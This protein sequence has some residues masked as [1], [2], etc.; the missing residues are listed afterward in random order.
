MELVAMHSSWLVID[1]IKGCTNNCKYCL[2]QSNG[3]NN[4]K[5]KIIG[6][7]KE[8]VDQLLNFKYYDEKIPL[9]LLPSTDAFLNQDNINYL[10]Q[11]LTEINNRN[12]C[13]DLILIT[14]CF[15]PDETIKLLKELKNNNRNVIVY[16]SYSGLDKDIEPNIKK[17]DI[18]SNF[19]RL[20][21]AGI[22]II[23]YFRPFIPQNS[24]PEKIEEVLNFVNNYTNTSTIMG[25]KLIKNFIDKLE[26]WD[27]V[28][29]QKEEC[30]NAESVWTEDAW[31]YFY[32]NYSHPQ[33][34]F[35]TNTCA[36]NYK[37]NKPSTQYYNCDEC[38][39]YNYCDE[40]QRK[41]CESS[42]KSINKANVINELYSHL[43]KLNIDTNN[44]DYSFDSN[45]GLILKN[46]RLTISDLSYLS[47]MLNVKVYQKDNKPF[48]E[49]Y[50][51]ALNGAK[52]KVMKKVKQ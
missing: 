17:E 50:N 1:S 51:S 14:K 4:H 27:E 40:K 48:E 37:L 7:P 36:L 5:P 42:S 46:V 52:P 30:L 25:L 23:H 20:S 49:I 22:D 35:Q 18:E 28:K 45:G 41:L 11:L 15:I 2:L 33:R 24:D 10:T 19:K 44:L 29:E 38:Q 26:I 34:V 31:N 9:A 13:N 3:N 47:Y 16:L 6:T 32:D 8:A 21:D 12:I 43:D 39:K